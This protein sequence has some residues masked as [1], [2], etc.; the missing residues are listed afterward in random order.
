M[1]KQVTFFVFIIVFPSGCFAL[2]ELVIDLNINISEPRCNISISL[3][4]ENDIYNSGEKIIYENKLSSKPDDFKIEY[5]IEDLFGNIIK[6]KTIASN[7]NSKSYTPKINSKQE[8]IVI[9]NNL[10][11]DCNNIGNT[12]SEKIVIVKNNAFSADPSLETKI[13]E[14]F[15]KGKIVSFYTRAKKFSD[16]IKLFANVDGQGEL[17]LIFNNRS[18]SKYIFEKA[19]YEFNISPIHGNNSF[20]LMLISNSRILDSKTLQVFFPFPE[21]KEDLEETTLLKQKETLQLESHE[22]IQEK[23]NSLSE[24]TGKTIYESKTISIKNNIP[25]FIIALFLILL[26]LLIVKKKS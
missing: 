19:T 10:N 12:S 1:L 23:I 14:N 3:I 15:T 17:I 20:K 11:V 5:W 21:K 18:Y 22:E 24:I 6:K 16:E 4:T 25:Y 26:V 8:V 13:F 9:K 7:T 2:Q